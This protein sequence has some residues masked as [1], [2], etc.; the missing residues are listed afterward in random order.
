MTHHASG[1]NSAR[2][3]RRIGLSGL[4]FATCMTAPTFG[5]AQSPTPSTSDPNQVSAIDDVVVTAR[6][7]QERLQEV[8]LA[9]TALSQEVLEEKGVRDANDLGQVAPGLSVQNTTA[10]RNNITYSI[11]GQGQA[12]GQNSPGVG[13]YFAEVPS[14]GDAIFDLQGI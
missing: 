1:A 13:P 11:R 14:V 10:N 8:P 5:F 9:V 7:R 4:L 2:P 3:I 12:F 6:R